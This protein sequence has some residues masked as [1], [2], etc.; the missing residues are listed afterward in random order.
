[1]TRTKKPSKGAPSR[2][3][4]DLKG[5]GIITFVPTT[6]FKR[7]RK[8]YGDT[9]GLPFVS[10]DGFALVFDLNGTP[11]RVVNVSG[12]E[13]FTP[14]AY[15]ILGWQVPDIDAIVKD[16]AARGVRFERFAGM[17]Q[18]AAGIWNSPSGA[19]VAWFKDPDGN[20]L[21]VSQ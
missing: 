9:L 13:K 12:M 2:R 8:F 18:D 11:L 17:P 20:V 15:T 21:S 16:L 10:E 7:A 19:R 4:A 5:L 14:A 3:E 1:M 6:D